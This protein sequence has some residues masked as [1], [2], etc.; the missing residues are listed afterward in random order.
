M[1]EYFL[2][3]EKITADYISERARI[4]NMSFEEYIKKNN[5]QRKSSNVSITEELKKEKR[6]KSDERSLA[7]KSKDATKVK[8]PEV[9][10]LP[11]DAIAEIRN[12][13]F[14]IEPYDNSAEYESYKQDYEF[15]LGSKLQDSFDIF[16]DKNITEESVVP[17]LNEKFGD[18]G[19]KFYQT[20]IGDEVKIKANNGNEID[21][22]LKGNYGEVD[23]SI[24]LAENPY[25]KF[26]NFIK[27][28]KSFNKKE[29]KVLKEYGILKSDLESIYNADEIL[30]AGAEASNMVNKILQNP[31][32]YG[33]KIANIGEY[34][35]SLQEDKLAQ[36]S[37]EIKEAAIRNSPYLSSINKD[38]VNKLLT[39]D[40]LQK[41]FNTRAAES[42]I[43]KRASSFDYSPESIS[44]VI[45]KDIDNLNFSTSFDKQFNE[46]IIK[47]YLKIGI[48]IDGLTEKFKNASNKKEQESILQQIN[49]LN[50]RQK[51]IKS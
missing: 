25:D 24:I 5:I 13:I 3:G 34:D 10:N 41:I 35:P 32:A 40:N 43:K 36:Y 6:D 42:L 18:L 22:L 16:E 49:S 28:N 2:N 11:E 44:N 9:T 27:N 51:N 15:E 23:P 20:G 46:P 4:A 14:E 12:A 19:F 1:F 33:I 29:N 37:D 26:S 8:L 7:I 17:K 21:V 48:E 45:K 31:M 30:E 50:E 39:P 38:I 47:D